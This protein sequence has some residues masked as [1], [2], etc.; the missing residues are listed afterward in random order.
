[1]ARTAPFLDAGVSMEQWQRKRGGLAGARAGLAD[2]VAAGQQYWNGFALNGSGF[3]VAERRNGFHE[4][5][6]QAQG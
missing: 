2:D 4:G 3:F 6:G 1:M 5:I